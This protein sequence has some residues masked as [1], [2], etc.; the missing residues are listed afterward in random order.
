MNRRL[1][2]AN[3][4]FDRSRLQHVSCCVPEECLGSGEFRVDPVFSCFWS[5]LA[6][7][8]REM[9]RFTWFAVFDENTRIS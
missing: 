9:Q 6:S 2:S 5:E 1:L 4:D 7:G 3:L 8:L